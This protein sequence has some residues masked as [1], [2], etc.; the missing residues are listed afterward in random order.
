MAGIEYFLLIIAIGFFFKGKQI[1]RWSAS[2]GLL[3][4][5]VPV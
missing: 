1:R 5:N 3:K 4:K 2:Y